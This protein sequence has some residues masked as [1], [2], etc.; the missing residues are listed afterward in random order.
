MRNLALSL[1][2]TVV[3]LI[4]AWA[5]DFENANKLF[6]EGKFAEARALYRQQV[7]R[8][9]WS[10]NL[11]YNLGNAERR[12]DDPGRAALDY[13]RALALDPYHTEARENLHLLRDQLGSQVPAHG[14][15]DDIF[16]ILPL[17]AWTA[18][19]AVGAWILILS[20]AVPWALNRRA[21]P[22]LI[23]LAIIGGFFA[24]F[25]SVGVWH[26]NRD[27]P[28]AI[29]VVPKAEARY[30]AAESAGLAGAFTAGS[31]VHVLSQRGN[32]VYCELPGNDRGWMLSEAIEPVALPT[33]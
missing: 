14:W 25:A 22:G 31:R 30:G 28:A 9:E 6:D 33:P 16:G 23:F 10:A 2:L 21:S 7:E 32:W 27:R 4:P 24:I 12:L 5:G 1:F 20:L 11:F 19:S 29:V 8:G 18:I 3:T 17:K 13:E 26:T 15:T